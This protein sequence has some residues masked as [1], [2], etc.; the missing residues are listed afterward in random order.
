MNKMPFR[1]LQGETYYDIHMQ[2]PEPT[3]GKTGPLWHQFFQLQHT[4]NLT[5]FA[6]KSFLIF[7][8]PCEV[9]VYSICSADV[10]SCTELES[11]SHCYISQT[12]GH[13]AQ[14]ATS[15]Q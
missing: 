15:P 9:F 3:D 11:L 12:T 14:L 4:Y 8:S 5:K 6:K 1:Q 10:K 7:S 13:E 2:L